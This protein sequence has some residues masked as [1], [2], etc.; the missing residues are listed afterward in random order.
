MTGPPLDAICTTAAEGAPFSESPVWAP[1]L[2][3]ITLAGE[4]GVLQG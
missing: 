3:A 2:E 4:R 1:Q